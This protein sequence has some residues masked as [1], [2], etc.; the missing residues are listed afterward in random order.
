MYNICISI[1]LHGQ[2]WYQEWAPPAAL[3]PPAH[4][5]TAH[6]HLINRNV[7]WLAYPGTSIQIKL[8]SVWLAFSVKRVFGQPQ[9]PGAATQKGAQ[10]QKTHEEEWLTHPTPCSKEIIY[11]THEK[12]GT[13][14]KIPR[15]ADGCMIIDWW[16][17]LATSQQPFPFSRMD[18]RN[19]MLWQANTNAINK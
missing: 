11:G 9:K 10:A 18:R 4:H 1:G 3:V 17:I 12:D 13:W 16:P 15:A 7:Y 6:I 8:D 14:C 19:R 2:V 5:P